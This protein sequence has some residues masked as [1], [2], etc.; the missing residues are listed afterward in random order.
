MRAVTKL[1]RRS[2]KLAIRFVARGIRYVRGWGRRPELLLIGRD[3]MEI[4]SKRYL[5][6]PR[7]VQNRGGRQACTK[8]FS[9]QPCLVLQQR[10]APICRVDVLLVS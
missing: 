9:S 8:C 5:V 2:E 10:P 3:I 7:V 6:S 1:S 4:L